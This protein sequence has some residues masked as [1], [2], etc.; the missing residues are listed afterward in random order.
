MVPR[1]QILP[2][3]PQSTSDCLETGIRSEDELAAIALTLIGSFEQLSASERRLAALRRVL[4]PDDLVARVG[5]DIG[6][7]RDPL[8][9]A[10]TRLR[11][12]LLRR[13]AGAVYTPPVIVASMV[14]W[15]AAEDEPA[16]VV[17]PGA[18]SGRFLLAAAA[19]FPRAQLIGI[20]L[21]PLAALILR[22]NLAANGLGHRAVVKV[23]DYR[24]ADLPQTDGGT[25]FIGNPPY[26]RHHAISERWKRWYAGAAQAYGVDASTLAGLH[27]HFYVRT[28]Q[29]ARQDDYG[30]FIT[31]A[32]WLD[33]N[34][35][36]ALRALLATRLGGVAVHVLEPCAMP[37]AD[38]LTTGAITCFRIG[39]RPTAMQIRTVP[40][41]QD[42]DNLRSGVPVPWS[43]L[44]ASRRWSTV[45]RPA[46]P[47]PPGFV[48][49]G[50]LCDVRRGQVTG[51]NAVWIAGEAAKELPP[52]VLKPTVTR[53]RELL[54]AG[55]VLRAVA[56]LKRVVDLPV[57]LEEFDAADRRVV[58]RF[59]HWAKSQG[60]ADSYIAKHRRAW[61]SVLLYDPAP[62]IC[63]YMARR[64]PA[65]VRNLCGA[66]HLNIAHG[67]YPREEFG[68]R[69]LGNLLAYLR[70]NVNI[71]A[72]RTYAG[73]LTKF[74]PGE[75]ERVPVPA[76]ETLREPTVVS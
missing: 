75:L 58:D 51:G 43:T 37:F 48:E 35:G 26:V 11:G 5:A 25:L 71:S 38:A 55:D 36:S 7:G 68:E 8:G 39:R 24:A 67:L 49:L 19:R 60:A 30:A 70:S 1:Q 76:L 13:Q 66:R 6:L 17:D 61:W 59:L 64:P 34:Y 63:T 42:L 29:L 65:F 10:F 4:P 69:V 52:R 53:A 32:E 20:E 18:G 2:G 41:I 33:V 57:E 31:S 28:L 50:E 54:A 40:T 16:R 21:D 46:A 3:L 72:G 23:E 9:E 47:A 22:A 62:I 73:G 45:V 12:P 27:L 74:E 14:E 15:A 44:A 56:D